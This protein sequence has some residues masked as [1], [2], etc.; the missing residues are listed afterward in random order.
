[1]FFVVLA[2]APWALC[3]A[4]HYA[5]ATPFRGPH[6]YNPYAHAFDDGGAGQWLKAN[7]HSHT[8]AWSGLT[9]GSHAPSDM[10]RA[11]RAKGFDVLAISNYFQVTPPADDASAAGLVEVPAYEHGLS[12]T[13]S[14]RLVLGAH[15]VFGFDVPLPTRAIKQAVLLRLRASGEALAI[16]HP[17]LRG[18]HSCDDLRELGGYELLEVQNP[19]SRSLSEWD[20]A[21]SAGRAVWALGGDDSHSADD[22]G[23]GLALTMVHA[24]QRTPAA[25]IDALLKGAHYSVRGANG[26][27]DVTPVGFDV[28]D[29]ALHVAFS[30]PVETVVF[31][32]QGG[33]VL[34]S[35]DGASQASYPLTEADTYVRVSVKTKAT[36]LDFNPVIRTE[37]PIRH[38]SALDR[39]PPE[40]NWPVTGVWWVSWV[41]VLLWRVSRAVPRATPR[42]G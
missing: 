19:Y 29:G 35:A 14:H 3:P 30:G 5:P 1:M 27:L 13:K 15:H 12:L 17:S 42:P 21:L 25:V 28:R 18:G 4:W 23:V 6:W 9:A 7:F 37:T 40:V 33:R 10:F 11:Y 16:A 31:V 36:T 22:S 20:C 8:R 32:G 39:R 2:V 34:A 26:V 38:P 24:T 41:A